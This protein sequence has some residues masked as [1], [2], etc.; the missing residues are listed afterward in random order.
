MNKKIKVGLFDWTQFPAKKNFYPDDLPA[1]WKLSFYANEFETACI[2]I[3]KTENKHLSDEWFDDLPDNFD[4]S[5]VLS[6]ANQFEKI[7]QLF[8]SCEL[9]LNYLLIDEQERDILLQKYT[10]NTVL[11]RAGITRPEQ[12]ISPVSLWTPEVHAKSAKIALLPDI[13]NKRLYREWIELWL[14]DNRQQELTLWLD[15]STTR[16]STMS[17][18]RTLVELMGY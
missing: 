3:D 2:D 16:Y 14:R 7:S 6:R 18:L 8:D 5:F 13:D 10:D 11:S 4:L 9:K 12:I 17:D 15:G 1:E